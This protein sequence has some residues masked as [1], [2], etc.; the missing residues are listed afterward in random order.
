M[1]RKAVS[2]IMLTLLLIDM[3]ILTFNFQ[4]VKAFG[5]IYIRADGSV[6]PP[7][8]PIQRDGN[9]YTFTDNIY[10][11]IVVERDNVVV[12]GAGY[13]VQGTG[14]GTGIDLSYRNN[15]T[16]KNVEVTN[17]TYGIYLIYSSNNVF[18]GNN[19]SL[20]QNGS[21]RWN[22]NSVNVTDNI[23]SHNKYGIWL[24]TSN[25]SIIIGNVI[26][27]NNGTGV[28]WWKNN[29]T[30]ILHNTI[31]D[32]AYDGVFM[33][34][35]TYSIVRENTITANNQSGIGLSD[36]SGNII[37]KNTISNNELDGIYSFYSNRNI[38]SGNH[39]KAND[40]SGIFLDVA[41]N[42]NISGNSLTNNGHGIYL[43]ESSNNIIYHNNFIN[44]TQQVYDDSWDFPD[45]PPSIS[46]WD[47]GYPSGGNYWSDYEEK[48]P[49]ATELDGSGIWDTP[50]V[51][52]DNNQDNYPIV[53][54]FPTWTSMLLI[55]IILTVAIAIT[56]RRLLKTP[57]R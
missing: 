40:W 25:Y 33:R 6:D 43:Y 49:N 13:K 7:T 30:I 5:N 46:I 51:I 1:N 27:S 55:L 14:S 35:V 26:T 54:E 21:W 16:L 45:V 15:V 9:I 2:G 34:S 8:A 11:K 3:L 56:K 47:D 52:D 39:I 38:I 24:H 53:P 23:V 42:N 12:D 37:I 44:N 22:C 36:S 41:F 17:F 18:A 10:D 32:N 50:Y 29:G 31:S 19:A 48:Y 4:P 57:I 28:F 20:N